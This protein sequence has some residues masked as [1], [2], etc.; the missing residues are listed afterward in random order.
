MDPFIGQLMCVG[1][2]FAPQGWALCQGQLLSISQ[3]TAL[4]SLLGTTYGGNGQTTFAL[5]DLRGRAPI[6]WGSGPG[7][8]NINLG[9]KSG[10]NTTTL[11]VT[12]LPSHNHSLSVSNANASQT[13]ATAGASIATPGTLSGRTFTATNGFTTATPNTILN[14]A[15]IS[16]VGSN[17]PFNNMQ[18][19][20]GMNWIIALFGIFPSRS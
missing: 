13:A 17:V 7:L 9:E 6:G 19:Y 1:F 2:N 11:N 16:P 20:I 18:P 12:N 3:N 8:Q 10:S 15:S 5:P 14:A 4:F